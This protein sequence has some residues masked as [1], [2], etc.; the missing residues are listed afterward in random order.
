MREKVI[1]HGDGGG[2]G[3]VKGKVEGGGGDGR[4]RA[5]EGGGMNE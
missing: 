5:E 3:R 2:R 1:R 4:R